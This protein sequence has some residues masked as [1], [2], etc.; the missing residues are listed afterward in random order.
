MGT[1]SVDVAVLVGLGI[2]EDVARLWQVMHSDPG[3]GVEDLAASLGLS[4]S[5]T[6]R[7]LDVL[8][9][10]SLVRASIDA[11]GRLV[12]IAPQAG[13]E[14]LL[15]LQ[16][17][18]LDDQRR[19]VQAQR[20]AITADI[21]G[22]IGRPAALDGGG[23]EHLVGRDAIQAR[24][25]E[26]TYSLRDRVD[27]ILPGTGFPAAML[28]AAKPLDAEILRRGIRVRN[29]YQEAIRNDPATLSYV[30]EMAGLGADVRTAPVLGQ[31]LWIG[32]GSVAMVP[33]DPEDRERGYAFVVE[34][35]LV[36]SLRELFEGVWRNAAP[37]DVGNPVQPGTGLSD[38]E[39]ELLAML[40]EGM[41]DE[42]AAKRLGV[43]L[44]TV[45]RIMADLMDRLDAGSRFEAG[46]KAAKKGWL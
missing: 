12:P 36:A 39:R 30:R 3:A 24:L 17:Q 8:A 29:L 20:D 1:A 38:T 41:T 22:R 45:R 14:L 4:E 37:L 46:I 33:L 31:R 28:Q 32:D 43:S 23:V 13:L 9:D 16:E 21:A 42:A 18:E 25:E 7:R 26:L 6:R 44:R 2:A 19:R 34:P 15:R 27:S 11:P 35:G 10:L 40:A 5:E